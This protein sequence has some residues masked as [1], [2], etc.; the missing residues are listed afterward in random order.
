VARDRFFY[1][2][3][4]FLQELVWI[5]V[6]AGL[7]ICYALSCTTDTGQKRQSGLVAGEFIFSEAPFAQCHASTI[8]E[9]ESGL[10]VAWF[11]GTREGS[12][13]VGVWLSRQVDG[14]W[15][16]PVQVADGVV[17]ANERYPCWN[18]VLFNPDD[19]PLML[20]Y[21]VGQNPRQWWGMLIT[22]EDHGETWSN[23]EPLPEG[24]WGPIKNKPVRVENG[25]IL[26]PSSCEAAGWE[27]FMQRTSDLG[28][29]WESI[30][31]VND[32]KKFAAIQPAILRYA[33]GRMQ[34]LCRS[35]QGFI[36]QSWSGDSGR[37]WSEMT[38]TVLP[39][40]NSGIDAVTLKNGEQLLVY[41]HS[42]VP[43]GK[44]G[45]QRSPLNVAVSRDGENWQAAFVLENREGRFSYP[46]VIQSP[47]GLVHVTYTY[48]RWKI[49]HV[50]LDPS[51]FELRPLETGLRPAISRSENKN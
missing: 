49:K 30:G 35:R 32:R 5:P 16:A 4:G 8:V 10:V 34:I 14:S 38:A 36:T 3:G 51:K 19:G 11:G 43:E 29:T 17:S 13:D 28:L 33:D 44:W 9:T 18:P 22:S 39:N 7:L 31:P 25:T 24:I 37:T 48:N 26:C 6:T 12:S 46:A 50:V 1:L 42:T 20:F 45:G 47:D 27:V 2:R 41:N 23:P 21:K 40:P 15:T